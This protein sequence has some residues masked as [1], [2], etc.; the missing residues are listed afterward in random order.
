MHLRPGTGEGEIIKLQREETNYWENENN[1]EI[2]QI[3]R[4]V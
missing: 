3:Q 2:S 1:S 4:D